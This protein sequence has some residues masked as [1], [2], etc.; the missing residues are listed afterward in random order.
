MSQSS[1]R[2]YQLLPSFYRLRDAGQGESLRALLGILDEERALI[3]S[4]IAGLYNNWFVET[5]D[6]W[7]LPYLGELIR[8]RQ[9]QGVSARAITANSLAYLRRK[10]TL[11][12]LEAVARDVT[13]WPAR[14]VEFLQLVAINQN[15]NSEQ[16]AAVVLPDLRQAS[17][18]ALIGGPFERVARTVD[19]RSQGK[20]QTTQVGLFL[21]RLEAYP[22]DGVQAAAAPDSETGYQAAAAPNPEAKLKAYFRVNPLGKDQALWSPRDTG[23]GA[24]ASTEESSVPQPL[25]RRALFDALEAHRQALTDRR[26]PHNPYFDR[27]PVLR[28]MVMMP[29]AD[30]KPQAIPPEK[31]LVTDLSTW[32]PPAATRS[33]RPSSGGDPQELPIAAA[34]DPVLGRLAFPAGK[35]PA[36]VWV[37]YYYG[38]TS[39]LG[40]GGYDREAELPLLEGDSATVYLHLD[41]GDPDG[42]LRQ[43]LRFPSDGRRRLVIELPDSQSYAICPQSVPAGMQLELRAKNRQRPLLSALAAPDAPAAP[44]QPA[45]VWTVTLAEGAS[46]TL[47][48]L[49]LPC[50]LSLVPATIAPLVPATTA[51]LLSAALSLV[52]CTLVPGNALTAANPFATLALSIQRSITGFLGPSFAGPADSGLVLTVSDSILDGAGANL[53]RAVQARS[54]RMQHVTVLGS[55]QVD[56][57]S[58]TSDSLFCGPVVA[59]GSKPGGVSSCYLQKDGLDLGRSVDLTKLSDFHCL[60]SPPPW[61]TSSQY[62]TPGYGQLHALCAPEIRRGASDEGELGALH[63]LYAAQRED[64]LLSCRDDYVRFGMTLNLFYAT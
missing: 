24:A 48:G 3:E 32:R 62:G 23:V 9:L 40:G 42:V 2:L 5:C 19:V 10:G 25:R 29:G 15:V 34:V 22:L 61:F 59:P 12:T 50:G 51:P 56:V 36:K 53:Q 49:L 16:P 58:A 38:C 1:E 20:Y 6:E 4:D 11:R 17:T 28:V 54:A 14:A 63:N 13:G 52:H 43:T 7:V 18:V 57:L 37:S 45:A 64:N 30:G 33:Y 46:L 35:L 44:V 55:V 47:N 27:Q 39:E 21:W 31:L 26:T 8:A 41:P 60:T